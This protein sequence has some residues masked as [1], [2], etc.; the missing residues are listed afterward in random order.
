MCG[1]VAMFHKT[2]STHVN[3][4][5]VNV[6]LE[7]IKHRGKDSESVINYP[8]CT[9]GFR[10]LSIT[11]KNTI[12]YHL[13]KWSVYINGEIY[14]YKDFGFKGNECSVI[15]QGLEK[16]GPEFVKKLNGMFF[17][18]AIHGDD[19]YVFRDRYGIK[20]IYYWQNSKYIV[21]SSEIKAIA[22]H[23]EYN[24]ELNEEVA[25]Q[26]NVFN[27]VFNDETLFLGI[28][29]L[30][31]ASIWHLNNYEIKKYWEWEFKPQ[32]IDYHD[33]VHKVR[34][35]FLQALERQTPK[36]VSY[37]SCLSGGVDSG[38]IVGN[39]P[40]EIHTFTVGFSEGN[41]ERKLAQIMGA[42][43]IHHEIFLNRVID[44]EKTI[45][46]LED[47][48]VG[49]SWSN[50]VLYE[51]A[52]KHVKVLFDGAGS[53]ELF[54][55]YT[56]RYSENNYYNIVNRTKKKSLYCEDLFNSVFPNDTILERFKFDANHFLEG[57]LLVGDKL[58]MAHTIEVRFPFLDNDLVDFCLT[59]PIEYKVEKKILK[60]AFKHLLNY[61]ILTNKKQGFSSPD[62]FEGEG[63]QAKKWANAALTQWKKIFNA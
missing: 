16:Y 28:R 33:A 17:I 56:W 24:F 19:V 51:E 63:N 45:Y 59:L 46:H 30:D 7:K 41:D 50:Y 8:K 22:L 15:S 48:R 12:G 55:G 10:R 42:F 5:I 13:G 58:S 34:T 6:M 37:G 39:L 47:L 29:K 32:P 53:D 2:N 36:E 38:I 54:S 4:G 11:E 57:V 35:L 60:D 62:W 1:I 31:K 23:P 43:R 44:L 61:K 21:V 14:N 9:V 27:N 26:W 52:S 18:F 20:P 49:A 3:G 25:E 40:N